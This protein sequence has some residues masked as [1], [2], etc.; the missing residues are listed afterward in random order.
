MRIAITNYAYLYWFG[1][2]ERYTT[3]IAR[4]LGDLGH[5][6]TI[7]AAGIHLKPPGPVGTDFPCRVIPIETLIAPGTKL[8][9][10]PIPKHRL[11]RV[12][13]HLLAARLVFDHLRGHG[14]DLIYAQPATGLG[15][16]R[17]RRMTG[18]PVVCASYNFPWGRFTD[19][20]RETIARSD[21]MIAFNQY[22][23]D[24]H[25]AEVGDQMPPHIIQ[26]GGVDVERFHPDNYDPSLRRELGVADDQIMILTLQRMDSRKN[27]EPILSAFQHV[28][29]AYPQV[30]VFVGGAGP[31]LGRYQQWVRDHGGADQIQFL[32]FV[33]DDRLPALYA[34]SDIFVGA[35]YGYVTGEAMVSGTATIIVRHQVQTQEYV[36]H[37][38]NGLLVEET[39]DDIFAALEWLI[40]DPAQRQAFAEAGRDFICERFNDRQMVRDLLAFFEDVVR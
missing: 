38:E 39:V 24:C 5:S 9:R 29:E 1:G 10:W 6:V 16:I 36:I 28:A 30:R 33:D 18:T 15:A 21:G 31:R 17:A 20:S 2:A 12:F 22:T 40:K 37:G 26:Q 3:E 19:I 23:L 8:A 4:L 7:Y 35:T 27:M 32:G 14:Y 13:S 25:Q 11:V 34:S